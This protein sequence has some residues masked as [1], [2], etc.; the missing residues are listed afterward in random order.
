MWV[1]DAGEVEVVNL[2]SYIRALSS[3]AF[4]QFKS[5]FSH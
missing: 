3:H 2:T 5:L 1:T 4:Q